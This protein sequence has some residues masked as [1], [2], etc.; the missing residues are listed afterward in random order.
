M[1]NRRGSPRHGTTLSTIGLLDVS[2]ANYSLGGDCQ[3][4]WTIFHSP[5]YLAMFR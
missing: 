4:T 1:C 5:S 3:S 2:R